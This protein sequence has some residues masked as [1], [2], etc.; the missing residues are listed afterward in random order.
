MSTSYQGPQFMLLLAAV[1][2]TSYHY[3]FLCSM[4]CSHELKLTRV[5]FYNLFTVIFFRW[6][7]HRHHAWTKLHLNIKF[8]LWAFCSSWGI[9]RG[10]E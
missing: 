7:I 6:K 10:K 5:N 8:I 9:T 1:E 3:H 2:L 4:L